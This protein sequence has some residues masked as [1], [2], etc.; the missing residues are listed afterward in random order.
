MEYECVVCLW[1]IVSIKTIVDYRMGG[2]SDYV[3]RIFKKIM[4]IESIILIGLYFV[5]NNMLPIL[6]MKKI[7][8]RSYYC[9]CYGR[10][11]VWNVTKLK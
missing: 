5:I 7:L 10:G 6:F 11:E 3:Y 9:F 4:L 2:Y 1:I 8:V